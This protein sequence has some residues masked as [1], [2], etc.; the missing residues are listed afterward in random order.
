V[1]AVRGTVGARITGVVAAGIVVAVIAGWVA[2]VSDAP[3][4]RGRQQKRGERDQSS[5]SL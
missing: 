5:V 2:R 4:P 3:A 1:I